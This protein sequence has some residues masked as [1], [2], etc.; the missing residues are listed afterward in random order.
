M[1]TLNISQQYAKINIT[2]AR[3]DMRLS[4]TRPQL[5][6][7]TEPAVVEISQPKGELEI[8]WEPFWS[9]IGLKTPSQFSR[10][11]AELGR[12]TAMETIARIAQ[13]GNRMAAIE[14]KEDAMVAMAA[15]STL[16]PVPEVVWAH[17]E[18]PVIHYT[19][20]PPVFNPSPGS[21][22]YNFVRGTVNM[23]YLPAQVNIS[24]AQYSSVKMWVTDNSVD[25]NV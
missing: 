11:C 6:I 15:D 10:D 20:R 13:D 24:M 17:L 3:A 18:P 14:S 9:S 5:M 21:V 1:L 7:D 8:D 19:A 16:Q 12:Q 4:T 25:I 2:T 22:K 23:D